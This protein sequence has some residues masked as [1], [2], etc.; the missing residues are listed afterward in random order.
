MS[1]RTTTGYGLLTTAHI[2]IGDHLT[3]FAVYCMYV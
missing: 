3:A 1:P 2:D